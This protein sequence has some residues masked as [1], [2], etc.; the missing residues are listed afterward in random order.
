MPQAIRLLLTQVKVKIMSNSLDT[1]GEF[2]PRHIGP[3][4]ADQQRMLEAIGA[5]SLEVLMQEVVPANI[6]MTR[7]LDLAAPRAEA[8]VLAE[9]K[10]IAAGNQV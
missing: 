2:I 6:R 3:G 4:E 10:K 1:S 5:A 9:M 8:D 7:E